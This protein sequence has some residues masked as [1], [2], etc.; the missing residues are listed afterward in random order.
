MPNYIPFLKA[1][2]NEVMAIKELNP[3]HQEVITPLFDF[4]RKKDATENE[5][6]SIIDS[7]IKRI[8]KH[9]KIIPHFYL[10]NF[11]LESSLLIDGVYNYEY[12]L[13]LCKNLPVVPVISIDRPPEH[14]A[15]VCRI[16]DTD[17][18]KNDFVAI[19]LTYE[20]FMLFELVEEELEDI[21]EPM[22]DRFKNFDLIL[23]CRVCKG[24]NN[25]V[26]S[27]NIISFTKKFAHKYSLRKVIISGSSITNP[28]GDILLTGGHIAI[29]RHELEIFTNA[30]TQ[31]SQDF[32]VVF[33]DYGI[34]SPDFSDIDVDP[35][36]LRNIM[37]PKI[38]YTYDGH[39][40]II[41]GGALASHPR[42]DDQFFDMAAIIVS[43]PFYRGLHYSY[44][45]HFLE[46]KSREVGNKVTASSILKPTINAHITFMLNVF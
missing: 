29:Q 20:D 25:T 42:G 5:Y 9:L 27:N 17:G 13:S 2:S 37:A 8:Q 41:R 44:G 16:M 36:V 1:K 22:L 3:A 19:R 35:R 6:K 45:D 40:Y 7:S 26:L 23:D 21:L 43:Q 46:E 33:A 12:A 24:V 39:H 38:I 31:L 10:D 4:P 28:I 18:F 32:D 15:S 30:S 34:V 14:I 11:D